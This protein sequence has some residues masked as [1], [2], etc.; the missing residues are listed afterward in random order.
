M[1]IVERADQPG[2]PGPAGTRRACPGN[3]GCLG[4]NVLKLTIHPAQQERPVGGRPPLNFG[5]Q[6]D[7]SSPQARL[8]GLIIVPPKADGFSCRTGTG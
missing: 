5:R 7:A 8:P 4:N 2:P 6:A 1:P 3:S